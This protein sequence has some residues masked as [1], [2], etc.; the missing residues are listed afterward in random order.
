MICNPYA[1]IHTPSFNF[2]AKLVSTT[3]F[4]RGGSG[5]TSWHRRGALWIPPP[6]STRC[7]YGRPGRCSSSPIPDGRSRAKNGTRRRPPPPFICLG[8]CCTNTGYARVWAKRMGVVF[9]P[10]VGSSRGNMKNKGV[11]ASFSSF[12]PSSSLSF[13]LPSA[14]L[15]AWHM[16]GNALGLCKFSQG[17]L[18]R[19]ATLRRLTIEAL[20]SAHDSQIVWLK[21]CGTPS[22]LSC[23]LPAEEG[24]ACWFHGP[25]DSVCLKTRQLNSL[26]SNMS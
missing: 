26:N 13:A 17:D 4:L 12:H 16:G 25:A 24:R 15:T 21:P 6:R 7:K 23:R 9:H 1:F 22:L 19:L 5:N 10:L 2:R 14:V 20:F 3:R 8:A 18:N 11:D